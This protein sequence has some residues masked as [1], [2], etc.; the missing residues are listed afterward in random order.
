MVIRSR[1]VLGAILLALIASACVRSIGPVVR[2]IAT[3]AVPARSTTSLA[4]G[5]CASGWRVLPKPYT[6]GVVA[7]HLVAA[8][9]ASVSDV[10]AV[11][12]R[13]PPRSGTSG[14]SQ[15]ALIEHFDG[16]AWTLVAGADV[17]GRSASLSAVVALAP[18]NAWAVGSALGSTS[19]DPQRDSLIEHWDGRRWSLAPGGPSTPGASRTLI[20]VAAPGPD[21]VWIQGQE[22]VA[23]PTSSG[24]RDFFQHWDGQRWTLSRGPQAT[25]PE[26]GLAATQ[27]ISVD[28]AGDAWAAGGKISGQGEAG[29]GDGALVARWD[30]SNWVE[31]PPPAGTSAIGAL[32]V[33]GPAD[34]WAIR[35]AGLVTANG[36][37]GSTG[38]TQL[39]HWNGTA[40]LVSDQADG[41]VGLGARGSTDVWAAGSTGG[42]SKAPPA[43]VVKHWDGGA[44][45]VYDTHP[46]QPAELTSLSISRDGAV[47]AFGSD[48]PSA[49][50]GLATVSPETFHNYLWINCRESSGG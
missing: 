34:V 17:G 27:S 2:P 49:P 22:S 43:P 6:Q 36:T 19:T 12:T 37:Y 32:A 35:G 1:H 44:W 28:A 9:A 16:H 15:E 24:S 23:G 7:D 14:V 42:L 13:F 26:S 8:S 5:R 10:W 18:D 4:A 39:I 50:A 40:W 3:S 46:P 38:P 20:G 41:L 47:V 25:S 33:I 11:G 48:Y 30:G 31:M 45:H 29:R 21:S